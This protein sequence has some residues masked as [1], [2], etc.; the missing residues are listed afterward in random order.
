MLLNFSPILMPVLAIRSL[1]LVLV[2]IFLG[3]DGLAVG[4]NL[5]S[6]C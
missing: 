5:Y 1:F 2:A 4:M 6:I 3:M